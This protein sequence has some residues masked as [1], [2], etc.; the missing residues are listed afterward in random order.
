MGTVTRLR[1]LLPAIRQLRH[2]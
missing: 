1:A 2:S